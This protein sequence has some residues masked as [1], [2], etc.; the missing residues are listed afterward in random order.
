MY[1]SRAADREKQDWEQA[2]MPWKNVAP[3]FWQ[4]LEIL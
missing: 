1:N 2:T 4:G 3:A